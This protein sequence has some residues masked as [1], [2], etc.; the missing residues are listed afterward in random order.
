MQQTFFKSKFS[1]PWRV[2]RLEK[3]QVVDFRKCDDYLFKL[4]QILSKSF[5]DSRRIAH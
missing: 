3:G 2:L 1:W 5:V 4:K